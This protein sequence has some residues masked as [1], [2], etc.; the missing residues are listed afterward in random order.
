MAEAAPWGLSSPELSKQEQSMFN[1]RGWF[2][3]S[4]TPARGQLV[5]SSMISYAFDAVDDMDNNDYV[6]AVI[7]PSLQV[8]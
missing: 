6:T 3:S 4:N 8:V 7:K 5:I 2:V 1:Y